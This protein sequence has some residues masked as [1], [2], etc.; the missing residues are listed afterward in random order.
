[1]ILKRIIAIVIG[2]IFGLFLSGY[3]LGK[4]KHKDITTMGS[5]NAGT[6]N[7]LR[8]FGWKAGLITLL[9]DILKTLLAIFVVWLLFHRSEPEGVRLLEL[10]AGFGTI[11]GHNFPFYMCLRKGE[12]KK[13]GKGIACTGALMIAF[14]RS[15]YRS[16]VDIY[17]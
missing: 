3:L 2:Y 1:M 15:K 17:L 4:A 14:C 11:L 10:Y 9:G 5:G 13:G 7:T 8:M 12:K 16:V 6:T